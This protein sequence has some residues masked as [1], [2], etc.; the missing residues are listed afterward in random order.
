MGLLETTKN[1]LAISHTSPKV[2]SF[3]GKTNKQ[4]FIEINKSPIEEISDTKKMFCQ[5]EKI[6]GL[7]Y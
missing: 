6:L 3:C 4:P 5:G 7:T 2:I 1:D